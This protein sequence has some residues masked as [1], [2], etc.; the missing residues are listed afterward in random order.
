VSISLLVQ[1]VGVENLKR[2]RQA[3]EALAGA[4]ASR[5]ADKLR[6]SVIDALPVSP[7]NLAQVGGATLTPRD[8]SGDFAKLQNLDIALTTH[9]ALVRW[10]RNVSPAWVVG[11]EVTAPAANTSLVSRT[12]STGKVGYVY[13]FL[14]TAGEANDFRLAWTSGGTSRS[15]RIATTSKGT[16]V[17]V[18]P[19]PVN[20]DLSADGDTTVA[21]RNVSAGS[22]GVVYQAAILYAEV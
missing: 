3:A 8:W 11:S 18:S 15:L 7:F 4:L 6:V 14:I 20:E 16:V 1:P 21:I 13:G 12:V 17:L 10:G 5:A 19:V 2:L 9:Q 22:S